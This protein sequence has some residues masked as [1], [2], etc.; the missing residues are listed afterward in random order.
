MSYTAC[1]LKQADVPSLLGALLVLMTRVEE[2][3]NEHRMTNIT[4]PTSPAKTV[5]RQA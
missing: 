4:F 5:L 1:P 2:K 3:H